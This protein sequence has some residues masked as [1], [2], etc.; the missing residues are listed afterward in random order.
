MI[1]SMPKSLWSIVDSR[2]KVNSVRYAALCMAALL[3]TGLCS[4]ASADESKA[5]ALRQEFDTLLNDGM[6][7]PVLK[8]TRRSNRKHQKRPFF[9]NARL[10][11]AEMCHGYQGRIEETIDLVDERRYRDDSLFIDKDGEHLLLDVQLAK[12]LEAHAVVAKLDDKELRIQL[13]WQLRDALEIKRSKHDWKFDWQSEKAVDLKL[14]TTVSLWEEAYP[15]SDYDL[16]FYRYRT[17]KRR[18][19]NNLDPAAAMERFQKLRVGHKLAVRRWLK[20]CGYAFLD[21]YSV[22]FDSKDFCVDTG[23]RG[24]IIA[25]DGSVSMRIATTLDEGKPPPGHTIITGPKTPK[26]WE[27]ALQ[28]GDFVKLTAAWVVHEDGRYGHWESEQSRPWPDDPSIPIPDGLRPQSCSAD[29]WFKFRYEEKV[30]DFYENW[31]SAS[32]A[33]LRQIISERVSRN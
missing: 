19:S 25:V 26:T 9:I 6:C 7:E 30:G 13:L 5:I 17:D 33:E 32:E 28:P 12:L 29:I 2:P 8:K 18:L 23:G 22:R 14:R 1:H 21:N 15:R 3:A 10:D 16:G 11:A 4:I 20:E 27:I 24:C 31:M